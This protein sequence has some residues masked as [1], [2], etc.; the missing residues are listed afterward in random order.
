MLAGR[1]LKARANMKRLHA[2]SGFTL[3]EIVIVIVVL[4][5][6]ATVAITKY[7]DI[8]FEA[9][10]SACKAAL[11]GFR[12]GIG[13]WYSKQAVAGTA[14]PSFPPIDSMRRAGAVVIN[15]IPPNPFQQKDRAP[16]SIVT[17]VTRGVIV[18]TR[19][20]WAY[21]A[22]TGEIWANT[23]TSIGTGT[24]CSGTTTTYLDE[25]TW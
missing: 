12:G 4:G 22:S 13:N 9:K 1:I 24:S 7:Q 18:G 21:K 8:D 16:D 19:G 14:A 6:L 17:G 25:N 3:I 2:T 11:G 5:I 10:E 23:N 15:Q 20:G